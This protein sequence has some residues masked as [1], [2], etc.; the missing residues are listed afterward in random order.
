MVAKSSGIELYFPFNSARSGASGGTSDGTDGTVSVEDFGGSLD[1]V[2]L[3]VWV[4]VGAI[5][6][7]G[8]GHFVVA[9]E[10]GTA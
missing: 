1:G 6:A 10:G 5:S 4:L 2:A 9:P 8:L 3:C 7:G